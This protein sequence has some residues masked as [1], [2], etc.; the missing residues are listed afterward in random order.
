M[1]SGLAHRT[2]R[3]ATGQCPVHQDRTKVQLATLGFL[4]AHSA[5]IHR[6]VRYATG[7]IATSRNS[8]LQKQTDESYS[9]DQ[10]AQSQS[11]GSEAHRTLNNV[12]P[13]WHRT[14]RCH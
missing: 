13:M 9:E 3:C 8:Q 4:Q 1:W 2:V 6:T 14:V 12:C 10:C 11:R 5:I 7:A